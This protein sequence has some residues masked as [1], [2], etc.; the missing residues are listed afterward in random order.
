MH[1]DGRTSS[2]DPENGERVSFYQ[3]S[4][5]PTHF[6]ELQSM[7]EGSDRNIFIIAIRSLRKSFCNAG[8][9]IE[10]DSSELSILISV[11]Y[12]AIKVLVDSVSSRP[13]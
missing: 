4:L 7:C 9:S 8:E 12:E 1:V 10:S 11:P 13:G 6:S 2:R 3:H 5:V